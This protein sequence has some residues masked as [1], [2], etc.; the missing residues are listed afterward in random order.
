M[1]GRYL[2]AMSAQQG[3]L[4][5]TVDLEFMSLVCVPSAY[6]SL[7]LTLY[8]IL[9]HVYESHYEFCKYDLFNIKTRSPLEILFP[10]T[11][12]LSQSTHGLKSS[13]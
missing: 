12:N 1:G 10:I 4:G 9:I 3:S 7:C 13:K 6:S 2:A 11:S 8:C 5:L